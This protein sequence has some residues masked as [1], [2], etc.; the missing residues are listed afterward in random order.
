MESRVAVAVNLLSR[1]VCRGQQ[2]GQARF[3]LVA[4]GL[5]SGA[6]NPGRQAGKLPAAGHERLYHESNV[7]CACIR[8]QLLMA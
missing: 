5:R 8:A 3:V 1:E 6:E 2:G 7:L 4:T